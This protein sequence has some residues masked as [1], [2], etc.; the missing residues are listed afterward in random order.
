[1]APPVKP[2]LA[3]AE[4]VSMPDAPE[5]P[6]E[7]EQPMEP[8]TQ[9]SVHTEPAM[10]EKSTMTEEPRMVEKPV[11]VEKLVMAEKPAIAEEIG[12]PTDSLSE[13]LQSLPPLKPAMVEKPVM[14]EKPAMA[15]EIG[16]ATNF[17]SGK[18]QSPRGRQPPLKC[19]CS[20]EVW[21]KGIDKR[22]EKMKAAAQ[23]QDQILRDFL[24]TVGDTSD[25]LGRT[26]YGG[27]TT[28][29]EITRFAA[30]ERFRANQQS[31]DGNAQPNRYCWAIREPFEDVE[32]DKP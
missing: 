3:Q 1:M 23:T 27:T 8:L 12:Q 20:D 4:A 31:D 26:S 30:M 2:V 21:E 14:T 7:Q 19:K 22:E 17:S 6:E 18:R 10:A 15:E 5:Q 32:F 9:A 24:R 28:I 25:R 13:K 16:Q 29:H 11:M